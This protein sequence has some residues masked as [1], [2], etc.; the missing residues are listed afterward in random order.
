[1][2]QCGIDTTISHQLV[3][4]SSFSLVSAPLLACIL[5]AVSLPDMAMNC[6]F[7]DTSMRFDTLS[8]HVLLLPLASSQIYPI[9]TIC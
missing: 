1:M 5:L 6:V 2:I 4:P 7:D 9:T 3:N 8:E